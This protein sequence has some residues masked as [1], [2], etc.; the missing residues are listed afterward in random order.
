M[1]ALDN[2]NFPL[3]SEPVEFRSVTARPKWVRDGE[4]FTKTDQQL[5]DQNGTPMWDVKALDANDDSF[6]VI[7]ASSFEPDVKRGEQI[8]FIGYRMEHR[9]NERA[10]QMRVHA[11]GIEVVS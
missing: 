9:R 8:Q 4:K 10:C 3:E 2:Q 7:V 5:T 6:T 1:A 11:D